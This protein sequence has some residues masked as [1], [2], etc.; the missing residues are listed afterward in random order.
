MAII[1]LQ[2]SSVP[3]TTVVETGEVENPRTSGLTSSTG[4][5]L[6]SVDDMVNREKEFAGRG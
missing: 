3:F 1:G 4:F 5:S 2:G 6:F